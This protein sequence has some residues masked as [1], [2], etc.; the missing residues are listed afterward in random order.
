MK[1]EQLHPPHANRYGDPGPKVKPFQV[2]ELEY[3]L[4]DDSPD[5]F[6]SFG[7]EKKRTGDCDLR[8]GKA[9][10]YGRYR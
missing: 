7:L 4:Q 9:R 6:F 10:H 5:L 8:P 1:V 3:L 2:S